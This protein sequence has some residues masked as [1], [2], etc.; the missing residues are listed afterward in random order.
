MAGTVESFSLEFEG[1]SQLLKADDMVT[2]LEEM[3]RSRLESP[4]RLLRWAVVRVEGNCF[5]CEGAYLKAT[6]A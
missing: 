3:L 1:W 5:R 6:S 4:E 2:P